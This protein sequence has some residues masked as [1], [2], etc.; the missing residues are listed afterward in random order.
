M[1]YEYKGYTIVK[2]TKNDYVVTKNG[3]YIETMTA[4]NIPRT[5]KAAKAHIDSLNK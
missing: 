5:L 1:T 3:E 4:G 2:V